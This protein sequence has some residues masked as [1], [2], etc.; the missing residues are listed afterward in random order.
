MLKRIYVKLYIIYGLSD[1]GSKLKDNLGDL[2]LSQ[3]LKMHWFTGKY[4]FFITQNRTE[5]KTYG[6]SLA[7]KKCIDKF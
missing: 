4:H 7:L 3:C 2:G 5:P 6:Q 1:P